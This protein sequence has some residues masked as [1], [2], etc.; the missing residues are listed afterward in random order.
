MRPA[1]V[2]LM[3]AW[4]VAMPAA[5][6]QT[7]AATALETFVIEKGLQLELVAAE[8]LVTSP[9]ALAFDDRGRMFVAENRGYPR[10]AKPPIGT[11]A[12]LED[13]NADGRMDKRTIFADGL[14]FPNGVLPWK[15]GLFVT[16][17]PDVLYFE[18]TDGDGHADVRR[19]VLTGFATTG[20]TQ[21]RVNA[22]IVGPDG[23]IWLASGLSGGNITSP[24]HPELPALALKSDLRFDPETGAFDAV[25]GRSQYGHSFDEAGRRFIC[26]NRIQVQH[27][28]L[29]SRYLRRNPQLAF[30]E[31]VQNCPELVPNPLM[32][33]GGGAARIFPISKNITTADSHA[34]TFSAACSVFIWRDGALPAA[35][36]GCAFSCDPTG[37]LVHVDKLEPRG[38]TFAAVSMLPKRE[39][40]AS[41]D[42]WFRPVFLA[43]GPDGALYIADMYRKVIEHPDYLPEEIRKRTDFENGRDMGRIWRVL[44]PSRRDHPAIPISGPLRLRELARAETLEDKTIGEAFRDKDPAV[45]EVALQL[46]EARL[47]KSPSLLDQALRLTEDENARVRFQCALTIGGVAEERVARALGALARRDHQ[48][49]WL[50]AAALSGATAHFARFLEGAVQHGV[51]NDLLDLLIECGR[52]LP[53]EPVEALMRQLGHAIRE[54]GADSLETLLVALCTGMS[55]MHG[56]TLESTWKELP[57]IA[58]HE[59]AVL[60][61]DGTA[62]ERR[63]LAVR[64]LARTNLPSAEQALRGL[65]LAG[66]NRPLALLAL[67]G[68]P[69]GKA[70]ALLPEFLTAERWRQL[71]PATRESFLSLSVTRAAFMDALLGAIESD[72]VPR[73]AIDATRRQQLLKNKAPDIQ[74]RAAA[75]F[76][77]PVAGDRRA[78]FES[79]KA[80]LALSASGT[81]GRAVFQRSCAIC[82]RL[83]REG[84]AVGPDLFDMRNQP[85]ESILLHIVV[86]DHEIAPAFAAY[87]IETKDGRTLQG[88]MESESSESVTLREPQDLHETFLRDKIASITASPTS[89]MPA[90]LEQTMTAQE[91][92]DL[93]AYLKGEQ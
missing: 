60:R 72:R 40:L 69:E 38:A 54:L 91:L 27:V 20:S 43:R 50:K 84:Y 52:F 82:H 49:R 89:L 26:M 30:S 16:C 51:D 13:T 59:I 47:S 58:D 25:D 32:R 10:N 8:P 57:Q 64:F 9:C 48:D 88:I 44:D 93:L 19:V 80:A 24:D 79:A 3:A 39:F 5:R 86:P 74:R 85:K 70:A 87:I 90:G 22:P 65:V 77:Q 67:K 63:E 35:Y 6:A 83:D 4:L 92:A 36:N 34:G 68:M 15:K 31:T 33:G 62:P 45:R 66:D 78:A 29:P 76:G 2:A 17:A 7:P 21:L 28:V 11:I 41:R 56:I 37:N 46:A 55:E 61:T 18:D 42:D 73:N 53:N 14:T 23:R 75:L 12:L 1:E 81:K 71:S